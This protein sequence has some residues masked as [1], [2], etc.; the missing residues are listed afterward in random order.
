VIVAGK[1]ASPVPADSPSPSPS[2]SG[3][4]TAD[5]SAFIMKMLS[6]SGL[7]ENKTAF[8]PGLMR[9]RQKVS[10]QEKETKIDEQQHDEKQS[11]TI[12][13]ACEMKTNEDN[14]ECENDE[15]D[16]SLEATKEEAETVIFQVVEQVPSTTQRISLSYH[17]SFTFFFS[18]SVAR[19]FLAS[20][21]VRFA[22]Q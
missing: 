4:F 10:Q 11:E 15:P 9:R 3:G 1:G 13:E 7:S 17:I 18:F 16:L 22:W 8:S 6:R 5:S 14:N 2:C 12:K 19:F 20:E 21:Q